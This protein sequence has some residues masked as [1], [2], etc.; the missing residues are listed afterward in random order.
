MPKSNR[1]L[2]IS[3]RVSLADISDGWDECYAIV[4]AAT[5]AEFKQ[6]TDESIFQMTNN[7]QADWQCQFVK[8]HLVSGKVLVADEEGN[9]VLDDLT[10][11]DI[12]AV[13]ALANRLYFEIMGLKY[14]PKDL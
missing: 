13:M 11:E 2:A 8:D 12:D 1:T 5:R 14:D 6:M 7:E 4:R 9:Q 10:P 3:K